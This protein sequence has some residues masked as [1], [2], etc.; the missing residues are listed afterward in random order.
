M[1]LFSSYLS[2][3]QFPWLHG[4]AHRLGPNRLGPNRLGLNRL[5]PNRLVLNR[6]GPNR[7]GLNRLGLNRLGPNKLGTNRLKTITAD[8]R[9]DSGLRSCTSC[10]QLQLMPGEPQKVMN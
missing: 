8:P 2:Y 1:H 9:G 5:G 7:L 10:N 6:L 3:T 4:H